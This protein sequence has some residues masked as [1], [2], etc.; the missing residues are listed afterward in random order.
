MK[1]FSWDADLMMSTETWFF[2]A[3][4]QEHLIEGEE[5][6]CVL[7]VWRCIVLFYIYTSRRVFM[8]CCLFF[9]FRKLLTTLYI[10]SFVLDGV[11]D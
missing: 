5:Q 3:L 1:I 9:L 11:F 6:H 4:D 7:R 10:F 2:L 8:G